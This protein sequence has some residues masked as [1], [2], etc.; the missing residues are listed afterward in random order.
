[1][2]DESGGENDEEGEG[3]KEGRRKALLVSGVIVGR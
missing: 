1:M 3:G 2:K